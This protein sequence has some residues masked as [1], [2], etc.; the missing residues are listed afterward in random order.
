MYV[1]WSILRKKKAT[2]TKVG[3]RKI[4]SEGLRKH[5]HWIDPYVF[6]VT[7]LSR[8]RGLDRWDVGRLVTV[9]AGIE[10]DW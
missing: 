8:D 3:F 5:V 9:G 10:M 4:E 7:S 1:S 6:T 2:T